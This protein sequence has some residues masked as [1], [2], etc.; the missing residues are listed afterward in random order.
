M[1]NTAAAILYACV[2]GMACSRELPTQGP[3]AQKLGD[4]VVDRLDVVMIY[5]ETPGFLYPR[6]RHE[7]SFTGH[8]TVGGFIDEYSY[9]S[10]DLGYGLIIDYIP[11]YFPPAGEK[12]EH[13]DKLWS[14]QLHQPG[15]L[16]DFEF[17]ADSP[18]AKRL[19]VKGSRQIQ[20]SSDGIRPEPNSQQLTGPIG[21]HRQPV[22]SQEGRWIF[23]RRD[24][25]RPDGHLQQIVK[26]PAHGGAPEVIIETTENLGGFAL[27][28]NDSIL[29]FVVWS[30]H[31]KSKLI[32]HDLTSGAQETITV[33]GFIWSDDLVW[34][35]DEPLFLTLS[36]PN[37]T[38]DHSADLVLVDF[39]RGTVE[40][41][42]D[43]PQY[44]Q[45]QHFGLHPG[46]RDLSYG[47][48]VGAYAVNVLLI[49]L[50]TRQTTTFLN[51]L[52]ALDFIWAPN[53]RDYAVIK[54][55]QGEGTSIF[56]NASGVDRRITTYPGSDENPRFSPDGQSLVFSSQR[57]NESQ[58]WRI[59]L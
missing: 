8:L 10:D 58:I 44:E 52:E 12:F 34:I 29:T 24:E 53:G 21:H 17:G 32:R 41:L 59:A 23:C 35:P 13:Y 5:D 33:E 50:D 46:T 55:L 36:D 49:N 18:H 9:Q 48:S 57:R 43:L 38:S 3:E 7:I 54:Y 26:V 14:S 39:K 27:T 11:A 4:I 25:N 40:T 6:M 51:R 47:V 20:G 1:K 2:L 28:N 31:I 37:S 42:V 30:P 56:I 16:R 19:L 22:F 15:E 45:V